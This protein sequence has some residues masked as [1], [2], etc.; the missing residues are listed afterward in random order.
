MG[1]RQHLQYAAGAHSILPVHILKSEEYR[2]ASYVILRYENRKYYIG[3]K[4]LP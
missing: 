2:I 3:F 1:V 4:I